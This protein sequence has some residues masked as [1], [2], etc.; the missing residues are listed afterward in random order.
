L[1]FL[2]WL[3]RRNRR[4]ATLYV[5]PTV[6]LF[7]SHYI[8][9]PL[10]LIQ[11]LYFLWKKQTG[12]RLDPE[13]TAEPAWTHW[14][15]LQGVVALFLLPLMPQLHTIL[16]S[17][18]SLN[19]Y[20][21]SPEYLGLFAF[22]N[23]EFLFFASAATALLAAALLFLRSLLRQFRPESALR[24]GKFGR[25]ALEYR[26][27]SDAL[28][29]FGLWYLVPLLLFFSIARVLGINLFVERYLVLSSLPVFLLIPAIPFLLLHQNCARLFLVIYVLH[30]AN[31][32]PGHY[33]RQKGEFS[34]GVPG[35]N[36]WRETLSALRDPEFHSP[37]FLFQSPFIESNQLKFGEDLKLFHYLSTPLY[38]FYVREFEQDAVLMPVHWWISNERHLSFKAQTKALLQ[39]HPDFVLLS[40]Q[41]FWN[42]FYPWLQKEFSQQWDIIETR[43]FTS[44]GS[45]RL[46]RVQLIP[47][48]QV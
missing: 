29:F 27:W 13:N 33:Y 28:V 36:E 2:N 34:Q 7:Y 5:L 31:M 18:Y 46:K 19:W 35:A 38:S 12:P 41:E 9:F 16:H 11:N 15:V 32:E 45:L 6:M 43:G 37:L 47:K 10:L 30:Y 3:E 42:N 44:T 1:A 40:T 4:N 23:G 17:R 26:G 21:E 25:T 14:M 8:F 22:I 48:Q 20:K 24:L 39:G